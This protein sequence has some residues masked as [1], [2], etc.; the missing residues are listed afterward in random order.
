M[1][2]ASRKRVVSN[3]L[4]NVSTP[5]KAMVL[6]ALFLAAT[7]VSGAGISI[8]Q[9]SYEDHESNY[10]V[11]YYQF[12]MNREFIPMEPSFL[13]DNLIRADENCS[14]YISLLE[15]WS[16]CAPGYYDPNLISETNDQKGFN[17]IAADVN[18][19]G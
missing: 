11:S 10:N 17:F 4:H 1:S 13:I 3:F 2:V 8:E 18:Q 16:S 15:L 12:V 5:C 9:F 7:A 14:Q 6:A 19:L